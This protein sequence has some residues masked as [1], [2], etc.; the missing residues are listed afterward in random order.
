MGGEERRGGWAYTRDSRR[1]RS[2]C[3]N[4]LIRREG[5]TAFVSSSESNRKRSPGRQS[6]LL[7][8]LKKCCQES[9]TYETCT[10]YRSPERHTDGAISRGIC[11][12]TTN[13]SGFCPLQPIRYPPSRALAVRARHMN[14]RFEN[15][16]QSKMHSLTRHHQSTL[17]ILLALLNAG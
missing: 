5:T 1:A 12:S 13:S 10:P 2:T 4:R 14:D 15:S 3:L 16:T 9:T 17:F 8:T 6:F 11:N 7:S